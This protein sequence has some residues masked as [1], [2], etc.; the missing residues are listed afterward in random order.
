MHSVLIE[1]LSNLRGHAQ[2]GSDIFFATWKTSFIWLKFSWILCI[3]QQFPLRGDTVGKESIQYFLFAW[4]CTA[5]TA[6]RLTVTLPVTVCR[7]MG[8][9]TA[10]Y[11]NLFVS[12]VQQC[13]TALWIKLV[14]N[15]N[16]SQAQR[17]S[18]VSRS[19]AVTKANACENNIVLDRLPRD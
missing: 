1:N 4:L 6:F 9:I 15:K 8:H 17:G 13:S 16:N 5:N 12:Y 10:F 3:L 7:Y 2:N 14:S 11:N 18:T 19:N